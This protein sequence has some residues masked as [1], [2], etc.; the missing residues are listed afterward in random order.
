MNEPVLE[1]L[2]RLFTFTFTIDDTLSLSR[3]SARLG[4][5]CP[6]A[7]CGAN[8]FE[9][10]HCHRPAGISSFEE[11]CASDQSMFLLISRDKQLALRGQVVLSLIHI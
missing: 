5:L 10:F 6:G 8:L 7:L 1:L 9:V 3:V 4:N 11:L 2:D